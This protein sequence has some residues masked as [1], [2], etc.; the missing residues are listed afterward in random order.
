M[1]TNKEINKWALKGR[2]I[3]L[4]I[5]YQIVTKGLLS[6]VILPFF[7]WLTN[8]FINLSGRTNLSS[9]D[10]LGFFFSIYGIPVIV[11]GIF[12]LILIMGIDINTFIMISAL[13][14]EN[15]LNMKIKDVLLAALKSIKLFFSPL[16]VV[17]VLYAAIILPLLNIGI[18]MGPL[19]NFKIPN[20]ITS[21]IFNNPFYSALYYGALILLFIVSIIY[22]F[23]I[24][25]ILLDGK[26]VLEGFKSSRRLIQKH[27]KKFIAD[28]FIKLF[29]VVLIFAAVT[30]A[31]ITILFIIGMLTS[32][33][34]VNDN[35][36]TII[37]LLSTFQLIAF[38]T[39][40]LI[41][42][43]ITILTKLF[44]K[45]NKAEGHDVKIKLVK[46][47]T[48]LTDND[49][50]NKIKIKTKIEIIALIII[51]LAI[52]LG[53]A[54]IMETYF[55]EIF[56]M[57]IDVELI[58]HRG[59]GDLGAEN[60]IQGIEVA[61]KENVSWT[62]IDVQRTADG[63]Y[64]I[65]HDP[66]F[67]RVA[68]VDKTPMEMTLEEIKQL[69]VKNEF[70]TEMPAQPVPTF[71]ELLDACKGK[72]GVFVELKGKSADT[73]MVDDVVKIIE[74]K[75]MLNECVILSL[76][77]DIIEYT[78]ANYPQIKTGFLYFFSIGALEDL[79]GDYLIMEE[80]EA[81]PL[82]I[83]EIHDAG[84]KAI[85]W[86]VNTPESID[87][88]IKSDVDGI[89][90]DYVMDLKAAIAEANQRTQLQILIDSLM[91]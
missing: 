79:K 29:K 85:V 46:T 4:Y 37:L 15:K 59:G 28:Y 45:Y 12:L 16:G 9:G 10:Y 18:S 68:G 24:H 5:K 78:A 53:T 63:E 58:A 21:V 88:F 81:T 48:E 23:S 49:L 31:F 61:I 13:S 72:I 26:T 14:E 62:E 47:A 87:K 75:N 38:F 8:L 33:L 56:K 52:N 65:N 44:Y 82:K 67:K 6:I 17:L 40:M 3:W 70:Q 51:L 57:K 76:D 22:I 35:V 64:V 11:L 66:S 54:T 60:T 20:F 43:A 83:E 25:F 50:Y 34:F 42:I 39:F 32:D 74:Q 73:Q 84:K 55:E 7:G 27:W 36:A 2:V 86:T 69:Q 30:V 90:T 1:E 77:Y 91:Q 19:K 89:I 41:P 80:R 71:E